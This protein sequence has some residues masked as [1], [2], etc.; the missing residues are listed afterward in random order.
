[1]K[2]YEFSPGKMQGPGRVPGFV[3]GKHKEI[4]GTGQVQKQNERQ[5]IRKLQLY[6]QLPR[7][8]SYLQTVRAFITIGQIV[9]TYESDMKMSPPS[10]S[11]LYHIH[12]VGG[13]S[14]LHGAEYL[15]H[16]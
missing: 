5:L 2:Y 4:G 9:R 8:C 16:S 12:I 1:M 15:S 6:G 11:G 14:S 10:R 13:K 3:F 7:R